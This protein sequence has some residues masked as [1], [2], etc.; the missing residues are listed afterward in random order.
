MTG[1]L[2]TFY[3]DPKA[4]TGLMLWRITNSWQ[5]EIRAALAPFGRGIVKSC[6]WVD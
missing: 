3:P 1:M 4:S 6:G 2:D 5:R